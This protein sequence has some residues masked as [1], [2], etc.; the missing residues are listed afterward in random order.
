[1][2][3]PV[4]RLIV[5]SLLALWLSLSVASAEQYRLEP[6]DRIRAQV[7][8][9]NAE[10]YVSMIDLSGDIRFPILG[11]HRAAGKT[12]AQLI[13]DIA[14][15]LTG[16]QIRVV[17]DGVE[18][19]IVLD[20][21]DI[22]LD[23][24][25]YRAVTVT[26]AVAAPGSVAFEPGLTARAAIG[27]AGGSALAGL[28]TDANRLMQLRG[29]LGEL[30]KTQA[31]LMADLWRIDVLLDEEALDTIPEEYAGV[32]ESSLTAEDMDIVR[33][34]IVA[35]RELRERNRTELVA[36]IALMNSRI[37]F[38]STALEQFQLA[39]DNAETRSASLSDLAD[40]GLTTANALA[41][42]QNGALNASS[43]VL[44][45]EADL[46]Q[47]GQELQSL[48]RQQEDVDADFRNQLFQ[49]KAELERSLAENGARIDANRDQ[50]ALTTTLLDD[51]EDQVFDII[52][53]RWED[54][55]ETSRQIA[56]SARLRPGDV[57]EVLI[58]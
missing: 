17:L 50:M 27:N 8:G 11:T 35:A 55:V 54:G 10:P 23:I 28:S 53:Y 26:G 51:D 30:L 4:T 22:F 12:V 25:S 31:W 49:D 16:R 5:L 45:T 24:D 38:L 42:A 36:R 18:R 48:L 43:R 21:R 41:A 6:G 44:T 32:L 34:R 13:N 47:A 15:D 14:L 58:R 19:T 3:A 52:L 56:P 33:A 29:N 39:A 20:E 40:R 57:V 46:A 2:L 37:G 9:I 1:M 7:I